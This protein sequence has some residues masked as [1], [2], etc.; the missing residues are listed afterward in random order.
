MVSVH[1]PGANASSNAPPPS[2]VA[3]ADPAV[4]SAV[5][6][7]APETA[8]TTRPRTATGSSAATAGTAPPSRVAPAKTSH[9]IRIIY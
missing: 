9:Q 2:V 8:S 5:T 6:I 4:I 3:R 7:A 1:D